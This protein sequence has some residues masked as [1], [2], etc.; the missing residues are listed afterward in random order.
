MI[1]FEISSQK[2]PCKKLSTV[3]KNNGMNMYKIVKIKVK[4]YLMP[5]SKIKYLKININN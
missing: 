4:K 5:I 3:F 1:S 2:T